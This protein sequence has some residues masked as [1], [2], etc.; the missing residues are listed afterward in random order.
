MF[1]FQVFLGFLFHLW[2]IALYKSIYTMGQTCSRV[3]ER[4]TYTPGKFPL[5][6]SIIYTVPHWRRN[7]LD[8]FLSH[9]SSPWHYHLF[10]KK[11][12][13]FQDTPRDHTYLLFYTLFLGFQCLRTKTLQWADLCSNSNC[14]FPIVWVWANYLTS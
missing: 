12:L 3:R 9:S 8:G 11:W 14:N 7:F 4:E 1:T 5:P 6:V 10:W 2:P 13:C